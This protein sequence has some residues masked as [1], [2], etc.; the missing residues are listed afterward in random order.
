MKE[1]DAMH[2]KKRLFI[3]L[4]AVAVL[5]A[6]GGVYYF[7]ASAAARA[8]QAAPLQTAQVTVGSITI[9]ASGSAELLA[10]QTADLAFDANGT[11]TEIDV[12]VGDKVKAGQVLARL[13]DSSAKNAL[14]QAQLNLASLTSPQAVANAQLALANAQDALKT[15]N[16][17]NY[18]MQQGHRASDATIR[19]A[20]A[21]LTLAQSALDAA[22]R[23]YSKAKG[24]ISKSG[25]KAAAYNRLYQA[26]VARDS[27]LRTLNWL[28]GSPTD[29]QQAQLDSEVMVAEANVA[30]AQA[31]VDYLTGKTSDIADV[32]NPSSDLMALRQAELDVQTAQDNLA[33]TTLTAP[34]DGTIMAVNGSAG[35]SAPDP[36]MTIT[37]IAHPIVDM[38][39]DESDLDKAVVGNAIQVSLDAYP[40]LSLTGKITRVDPALVAVQGVQTVHAIGA[41]DDASLQKVASLP[42]GLTASV[43]VI[44]ASANN[45][46][47]VPIEALHELSAGQYGVFVMKNGQPTLQ[48]V[49]VGLQTPVYAE[50]KSG[51]LEGDVVT[52][53]VVQSP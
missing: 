51:L 17:N 19:N 12:Q 47:L 3:S 44:A 48:V 43:T 34:F 21:A 25:T 4:A 31:L 6:A 33:A 18:V 9:S 37:D 40:D 29:I 46:L 39:L 24:N 36:V 5:L 22:E 27:A 20:K 23:A 11:L 16:Y 45:V 1:S 32:A 52:T 53:G 14:Q 15:A 49:E 35:E 42:Y 30:S 7:R 50:I 10:Q 26:I 38:T 28:T 2:P 8:Q 41:L 13:D